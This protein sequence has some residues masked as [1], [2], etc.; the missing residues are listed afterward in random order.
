MREDLVWHFG[1]GSLM[2]RT[3]FAY[4]AF[5]PAELTGWHRQ[6]CIYS[7][8]YRGTTARPGLVLGLAPGGRCVG[9]A[10]GVDPARANEVLAYLDAR[11][12]LDDYVY[13]RKR[14][15]LRLLALDQT[16]E[17][18]CY[19]A[20]PEHP[21]FAGGLD[22]EETIRLVRQGVGDAG[23]NIDYVRN[24]LAHLEE[25]GIAEPKLA[26]LVRKLDAPDA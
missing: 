4:E 20:R 12:L 13:E 5:E 7:H 24:T 15:P 6:L 3:G 19:V 18:W 1:Y 14:L 21:D 17:A 25:I 9:R 26:A 16:V 22:E 2:W 8:H 11:E 23:S 10:I